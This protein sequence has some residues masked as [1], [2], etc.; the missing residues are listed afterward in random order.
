MQTL[1]SSAQRDTGDNVHLLT[2][3]LSQSSLTPSEALSH[4]LDLMTGGVETV[5]RRVYGAVGK[6]SA[7]RTGGQGFVI[8]SLSQYVIKMFNLFLRLLNK[9][10]SINTFNGVPLIRSDDWG[11]VCIW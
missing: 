2:Y 3:L 1:Q 7:H 11:N 10:Y 5:S 6:E 9:M 4:A 8:D